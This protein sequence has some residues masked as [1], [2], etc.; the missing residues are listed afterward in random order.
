MTNDSV[1]SYAIP[2][3][4]RTTALII[5]NR[6]KLQDYNTKLY[7]EHTYTTLNTSGTSGQKTMSSIIPEYEQGFQNG[8]FAVTAAPHC[9]NDWTCSNVDRK[10]VDVAH[11]DFSKVFDHVSQEKPIT[12]YNR[13][14]RREN[15]SFGGTDANNTFSGKHLNQWRVETSQHA[16]DEQDKAL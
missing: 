14:K 5:F 4:N 6:E 1:S 9:L 7:T 13:T 15:C 11:A 8:K 3:R 16:I 2:F 12:L 10:S